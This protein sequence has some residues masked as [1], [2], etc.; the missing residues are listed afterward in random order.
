[1]RD[2]KN[3]DYFHAL[4]CKLHINHMTTGTK[5]KRIIIAIAIGMA[6]LIRPCYTQAQNKEFHQVEDSLKKL[7]HLVH[8]GETDQEKFANNELLLQLLGK[9]L[10]EERSF[11]YPFDSLKNMARL[12]APDES[13][14][15]FNWNLPLENGTHEYFGFLQVKGNRDYGY[16]VYKLSDHSADI[17]S[18]ENMLLTYDRWFGAL[19]Y[20]IVQTRY[21]DKNYY[22]LL[23]WD[24]NTLMS[25]KKLIDV[26]SFKSNGKPQFGA[27]IF[28]KYPEKDKIVRVVFEYSSRATMVLRYESQYLHVIAQSKDKKG[29]QEKVKLEPMIIFDNLVPMDSRLS[30]N[31]ADLTG[32]YQF[33]VPETNILNGFIEKDGRWYFTKDI[34]ARNP[35]PPKPPK[36]KKKKK[37]EP[38]EN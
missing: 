14:R 8:T 10:E 37:S 23:A 18:P 2:C 1:M 34:D 20:K 22:T 19:Y 6:L 5:F 29:S 38:R 31:S 12:Y 17:E 9:T 26:L 21:K 4:F 35:E 24:G 13:F 7:L 11:K 28:K 15:I 36:V 30:A 3:K 27:P 25:T 32:Q 33:Y 16:R